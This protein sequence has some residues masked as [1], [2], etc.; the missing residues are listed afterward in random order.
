MQLEL[1]NCLVE[2]APGFVAVATHNFFTGGL[3]DKQNKFIE[4]E[5]YFVYS[6]VSWLITEALTLLD[7]NIPRTTIL[8]M[9]AAL[10]GLLW[11][12]CLKK[13]LFRLVN[14]C[15]RA[16]GKCELVDENSMLS[17]V[18]N[19]NK[20]HYLLIYENNN[21]VAEGW[22]SYTL[23][24]ESSLSLETDEEAKKH[25]A[26]VRHGEHVLYYLDK[27]VYIKEYYEL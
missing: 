8:L 22:L 26:H 14:L 27:N 16:K 25:F 19:D 1:F 2:L 23:D 18:T 11:P 7:L 17:M 21:L 9:V 20:P 5:R 15:S 10:L 3:H 24:N 6:G 13:R 12:L 4:Y